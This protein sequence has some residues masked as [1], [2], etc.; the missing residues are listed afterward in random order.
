MAS[1]NCAKCPGY[2][3]SYPLIQ[4]NKRDVERLARYFGLKFEQAPHLRSDWPV[5]E[6]L[7]TDAEMGQI[8][9]RQV[10]AP[11]LVILTNIAQNI[12]QLKCDAQ[13]FR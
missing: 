2:C 13:L 8:F 5:R 10:H 4:L 7:G 3:C 1:Y 6:L 11:H 9:E 12:G